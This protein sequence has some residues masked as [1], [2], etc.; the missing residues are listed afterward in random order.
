MGDLRRQTYYAGKIWHGFN[1]AC[2]PDGVTVQACVRVQEI[3]INNLAS[4]VVDTNIGGPGLR[5]LLSSTKYQRCWQCVDDF[6]P[7]Q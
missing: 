2:S 7:I 5:H 3:D 6:C 4:M 1:D